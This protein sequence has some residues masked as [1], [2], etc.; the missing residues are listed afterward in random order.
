LS[1]FPVVVVDDGVVVA[2]VVGGL[3]LVPL[4]LTMV[5]YSKL[6]GVV[7][8]VLNNKYFMEAISFKDKEN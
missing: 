3:R 6:L 5:T 2:K 1:G 8:E 7:V 4:P